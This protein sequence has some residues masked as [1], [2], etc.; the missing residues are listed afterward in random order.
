VAND[1][2]KLARFLM[3]DGKPTLSCVGC[4]GKLAEVGML[5]MTDSFTLPDGMRLEMYDIVEGY[6]VAD[7]RAVI[8]H[9]HG[10]AGK[11]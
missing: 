2:E 4:L 5:R 8:E 9:G 6:T 11:N 3:L 1:N 7:L 10:E